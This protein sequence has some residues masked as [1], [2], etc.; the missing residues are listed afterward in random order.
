VGN[1]ATI[2]GIATA[3]SDPSFV[4][5]WFM[6]VVQDNGSPLS[7]TPDATGFQARGGPGGPGPPGGPPAGPPWPP[8]FPYSCPSPDDAIPTFNL[9]VFPLIGGDIVVQ[10][11]GQ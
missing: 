10:Q 7:G 1:E 9:L 3:A 8:G 6:W 5:Q 4:G 11:R 2:G